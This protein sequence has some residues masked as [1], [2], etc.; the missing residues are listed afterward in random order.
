MLLAS[1]AVEIIGEDMNSEA[2]SENVLSEAQERSGGRG[3]FT[4]G[5]SDPVL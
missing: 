5:H 2:S 4:S 3:P 1:D